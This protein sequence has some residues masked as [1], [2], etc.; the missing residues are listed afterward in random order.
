[1]LSGS[2]YPN[3]HTVSHILHINSS[4]DIFITGVPYGFSLSE[5][6]F[7]QK[8]VGTRFVIL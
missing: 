2:N 6:A 8:G 1:M 5:I 3:S 7:A 4:D